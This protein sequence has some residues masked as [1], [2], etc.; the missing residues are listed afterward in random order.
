MG[1]II[2]YAT[3]DSFQN[4]ERNLLFSC[5]KFRSGSSRL[6][7]AHADVLRTRVRNNPY[8]E[9]TYDVNSCQLYY[10]VAHSLQMAWLYDCAW[11]ISRCRP[12]LIYPELLPTEAR[13]LSSLNR[14]CL[15]YTCCSPP[16]AFVHVN[17]L[18]Q[19]DGLNPSI[20]SESEW[21]SIKVN[22]LNHSKIVHRE[23]HSFVK[24]VIETRSRWMADWKIKVSKFVALYLKE[25]I[26]DGLLVFFMGETFPSQL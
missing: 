23:Q 15:H 19:H 22:A 21:N 20:W 3:K 10:R 14:S 5:A 4:L 9:I 16:T 25:G 12:R 17:H 11:S 18:I 1:S 6:T 13:L 2:A 26:K 8:S 7:Y 24:K